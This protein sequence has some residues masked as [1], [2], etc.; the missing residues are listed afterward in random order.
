MEPKTAP[1]KKVRKKVTKKV[2]AKQIQQKTPKKTVKEQKKLKEKEK[3]LSKRQIVW[4][5]ITRPFLMLFTGISI[6]SFIIFLSL[7]VSKTE[8]N[9]AISLVLVFATRIAAVIAPVIEFVCSCFWGLSWPR[10]WTILITA[11]LLALLT[12]LIIS[13]IIPINPANIKTPLVLI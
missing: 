12:G 13:S 7:P 1:V 8:E 11:Q 3:P 6:G 9:A 5:F 2:T 4:A 10:W